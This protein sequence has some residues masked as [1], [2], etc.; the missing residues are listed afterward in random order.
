MQP[1]YVCA[2]TSLGLT[3]DLLGPDSH[4]KGYH[5]YTSY[6][7]SDPLFIINNSYLPSCLTPYSMLPIHYIELD[8]SRMIR[9]LSSHLYSGKVP[10][11]IYFDLYIIALLL[12]HSAGTCSP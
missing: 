10:P 6:N 4:T 11:C 5:L 1:C 2:R 3:S 12:R 7:M 8:L 9:Q